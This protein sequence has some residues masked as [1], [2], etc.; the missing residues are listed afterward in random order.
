MGTPGYMPIGGSRRALGEDV[1]TTAVDELC[2]KMQI[3]RQMERRAL[4]GCGNVYDV[5]VETTARAPKRGALDK[6]R[7]LDK[8]IRFSS[9]FLARFALCDHQ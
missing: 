4:Y 2:E 5:L 8:I 7:H 6:S 1:L 3:R 9:I